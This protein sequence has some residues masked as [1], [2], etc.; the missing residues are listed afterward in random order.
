VIEHFHA[1]VSEEA[2][3]LDAEQGLGVPNSTKVGDDTRGQNSKGHWVDQSLWISCL[4][5]HELLIDWLVAMKTEKTRAE[6]VRSGG[7]GFSQ[8]ELAF[9]LVR[10]RSERV[11][12]F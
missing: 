1:A 4:A 5:Q 6:L 10:I 2:V 11:A 7:L 12:P 8:L 3:F 9:M